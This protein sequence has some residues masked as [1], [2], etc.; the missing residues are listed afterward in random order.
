M[1]L[2]TLIEEVRPDIVGTDVYI[3]RGF[4]HL[5]MIVARF[6]IIEPLWLH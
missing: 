6:R 1:E 5:E 2:E 4:V 3:V